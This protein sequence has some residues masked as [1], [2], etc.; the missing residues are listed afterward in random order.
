MIGRLAQRLALAPDGNFGKKLAMRDMPGVALGSK[1][2]EQW[3][4]GL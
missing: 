1:G 4:C 3:T 2:R